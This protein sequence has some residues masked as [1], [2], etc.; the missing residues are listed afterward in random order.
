MRKFEGIDLMLVESR[1]SEEER[2][3]RDTVRSF[4]EE[5]AMPLIL[6]HYENGTFPYELVEPMGA[7]GIFGPTIE[8]YGCAGVNNVCYGLMMQELERCDS[9][10]RSF[11]SVQSSLVMFPIYSYGS[12]E[13]KSKWL[14]EL[15]KGRKIGCFGLTEP[16]HGSNPAG[17]ATTAF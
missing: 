9:G 14:P 1:L 8:G 13:Q 4:V 11:A 6:E 3:V 5:R 12:E 16:D 7:L 10:L 15:A 17:M 2:M